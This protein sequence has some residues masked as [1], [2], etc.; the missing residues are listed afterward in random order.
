MMNLKRLVLECC[1]LFSISFLSS[2]EQDFKQIVP[3]EPNVA[4]L[5]KFV[6]TPV[7]TYTGI[8]NISL[9]LCQVSQDGVNVPITLNYHAGGIKVPEESGNTGLGWSLF[10]GGSISRV[11]DDKDDLE[12]GRGF[13]PTAPKVSGLF[14]PRTGVNYIQSDGE[15]RFP[16][17]GGMR[18][19]VKP[20]LTSDRQTDWVPDVFQFN[21]NGY[22]GSFVLKRDKTVHFL[23]KTELKINLLTD[24][25]FVAITPEGTKYFF[26]N[27]VITSSNQTAASYQYISSWNLTRIL[28]INKKTIDFFYDRKESMILIPSF[29]QYLFWVR[30]LTFN[31][32]AGIYPNNTDLDGKRISPN[33]RISGEYLSKIKTS[34]A[35]VNF[36]Y[37][38]SGERQDISSGYFLK[39]IDVKQLVNGVESVPT[40]KTIDF[41]YSYFGT[42]SKSGI[43][44]ENGDYAGHI[45]DPIHHSD[46]RLRLRLDAITENNEKTH[47][48]DY[49]DTNIPRKTS[50]SQDHWGFYNGVVNRRSFIPVNDRFGLKLFPDYDNYQPDRKSSLK[51]AKVFSLNKITYPTGGY[52]EYDYELHTFNADK[53]EPN[54]ELIRETITVKSSTF[55]RENSGLVIEEFTLDREKSVDLAYSFYMANWPRKYMK[56]SNGSYTHPPTEAVNGYIEIRDANGNLVNFTRQA[57]NNE[58]LEYPSAPNSPA[59]Y[60]FS[61]NLVFPAGTYTVRV[62]FNQSEEILGESKLVLSYDKIVVSETEL[63]SQGAGLR[64][65]SIKSYDHDDN[66]LLNRRYA[67]H[68]SV[69]TKKYS[70]GNLRNFPEYRTVGNLYHPTNSKYATAFSYNC[71]GGDLSIFS[72]NAVYGIAR[73]GSAADPAC[74]VFPVPV[75]V[76]SSSSTSLYQDQGSY[77]GY[78]EVT[79]IDMNKSG[80]VVNGKQVFKYHPFNR[81]PTP[82]NW[83]NSLIYSYEFPRILD[84]EI[85]LLRSLETYA[86]IN[87][88]RYELIK[89]TEM[90]YKINGIPI[91]DYGFQDLESNTDF[92]LGAHKMGISTALQYD[93]DPARFYIQLHPYY[94]HLVQKT[95]ETETIFDTEDHTSKIVIDTDY[96][97]N[98]L[99]PTLLARTVATNSDGK[100]VETRLKYPDDVVSRTALGHNALTN[101]E[102]NALSRLKT[103]GV[104][105]RVGEVVQQEQIIGGAT[106]TTRKGF[107]TWNNI[108]TL[109]KNQLV[110]K[111]SS[112]METRLLFHN[113]DAYGNPLE[114]SKANGTSTY[115]I[116]GYGDSYPI[117]KIDNFTTAQAATIS[118]LMATA[119]EK[120]NM[121]DDRTIGYG[122]KE[123]A[124]RRALMNIRNHT[125][126]SNAMVTTYTYD[127]I[128][129]VTSITDPKGYTMYYSYDS[130]NRLEFVK[131]S[132]GNLLKENQYHYKNQ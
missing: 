44:I 115:Y 37:S 95:K 4:S 60:L 20:S 24:D 63:Y 123:G 66:E 117:A 57:L 77:V 129:G 59:H 80:R 58:T 93:C 91:E 82:R 6:Q 121:D 79:V 17:D 125:A 52:T 25:T 14:R 104:E 111:N 31:R 70:H 47:S 94:S 127:P 49:Y 98:D 43:T 132:E 109:Q 33:R 54:N 39:R 19:Y 7:N 2:Q 9:P 124:L 3:A 8:P 86:F 122:G 16:Y 30:D 99:Y 130:L 51:Y 61:D 97:Y 87:F 10:A 18:R 128:I 1:F 118:S 5:M 71:T 45:P 120:S 113:Y 74:V 53:G 32:S 105:C 107:K 84:P 56:T 88:S 69:G 28:T 11:V 100:T 116:W 38:A 23:K 126:L 75:E 72:I 22:S 108:L 40:V 102:F 131:D 64:I 13:M 50:L 21:F 46:Y 41:E 83:K 35:V 89:K 101:E 42:T 106:M 92:V 48:F 67:Y 112:A 119:K 12:F 68:Y 78:D 114:T 55:P 34:N 65:R 81:W 73:V 27:K 96:Y 76:Y 36:S 29:T 103:D 62:N 90:S 110:A 15:C 85:G 26:E